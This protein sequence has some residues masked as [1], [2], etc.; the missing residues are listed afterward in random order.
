MGLLISEKDDQGE[1]VIYAFKLDQENDYKF[2]LLAENKMSLGNYD[3]IQASISSAN[4]YWILF[5]NQTV[6]G[7]Q[8]V[9]ILDN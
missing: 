7:Y 4:Q 5:S 6:K 9:K 3:I 1:V 8:T 2:V